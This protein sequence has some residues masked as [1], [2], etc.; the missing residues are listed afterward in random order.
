[1]AAT[2]IS[3]DV[4]DVDAVHAT[5]V[6]QGFRDR[7]PAP[8]RGVGVRRLF[9]PREPRDPS[10]DARVAAHTIP[11]ELRIADVY[12]DDGRPARMVGACSVPEHER[13]R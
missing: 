13:G 12:I 10:W 9:M 2:G 7:L 3:V 1:M 6:K 5:A 11:R 4:A 8:R